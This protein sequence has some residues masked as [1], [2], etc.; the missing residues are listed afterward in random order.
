MSEPS[1]GI[2][3]L[4]AAAIIAAGGSLTIS[5]ADI[6]SPEMNGKIFEIAYHDDKIVLTLVEGE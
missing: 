1:V 6:T 5:E 3:H 2:E 4:L